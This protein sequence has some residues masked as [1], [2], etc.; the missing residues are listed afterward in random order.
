MKVNSDELIGKE[1]YG[2]LELSSFIDITAFVLVFPSRYGN[3]KY[4][5][6][7]FFCI[8]EENLK[9]RVRKDYVPYDIWE[10]QGYIKTTEGNVVHY[11]FIENFIDELGAK[12][13]IK[14]IAFDRWGAV[15]MIQNLDGMG[16]TVVPL[17]KDIKI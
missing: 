16:F 15:Q 6:L 1:C 5:I 4:I 3:E 2:G 12:Y 17:D 8:P 10:K 14:E 11:G 9:L 7:P 13:N